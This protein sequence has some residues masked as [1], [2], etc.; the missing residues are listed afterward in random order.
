MQ[1]IRCMRIIHFSAVQLFMYFPKKQCRRRI[2]F[3]S[4]VPRQIWKFGSSGIVQR[5]FWIES[6]LKA[7]LIAEQSQFF[8]RYTDSLTISKL[9]ENNMAFFKRPLSEEQYQT[10]MNR[11]IYYKTF[12]SDY[13]ME[14]KK[15][16]EK[17]SILTCPLE[18]DCLFGFKFKDG[19]PI[20]YLP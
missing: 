6:Q 19:K 9:R 20:K 17:K 10:V 13:N 11:F 8:T 14:C 5:R 12:N 16:Y 15:A 18:S 1:K 3:Y 2:S 7:K 4:G